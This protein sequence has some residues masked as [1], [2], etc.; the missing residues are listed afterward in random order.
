MDHIAKVSLRWALPILSIF[1]LYSCNPGHIASTATTMDNDCW[2]MQDTLRMTFENTDT[3]QVYQ[4]YF[5]MTFTED[6][7][8]SN[9][10]VR[11]AVRAPSGE[12]NVL[13]SRFD[14]TTPA[15]EWESEPSGEEIPFTLN[16]GEGLRLNQTGE[17]T[18]SL[19]HFMRDEQICGVRE[20]GLVLD[21]LG[22]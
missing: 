20:V 3:Q 9:L 7:T 10:Y 18:I 4:L 2:S 8:Y 21:R 6:Y 16:L 1:L 13:P 14:L 19:Y 17:Y 12:E 11:A 22:E 5:P 15:G